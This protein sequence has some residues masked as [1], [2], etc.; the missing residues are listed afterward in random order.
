[1]LRLLPAALLATLLALPAAA[2]VLRGGTSSDTP[3]RPVTRAAAITDARVIVAPGR[4]LERA[5]VVVRDGRIV[6]VGR[7]ARVPFDADVIAGDSLW[8]YAGFVDAYA[9]AGVQKPEDMGSYNGDRGDPPRERAGI[10]PDVD[11]R[12]RYKPSDATVKALREAGFGA[13]HVVPGAGMLPGMGGVVLLRDAGRGERTESL[14]L[15]G[16]ETALAQIDGASG[17]YP[18][19]PMGVLAVFRETMENA[20]R[21]RAQRQTFSQDA[22]RAL[23][24]TYDP[25]YD[26][27][28]PVVGGERTLVFHAETWLS[29]YRALRASQEAGVERLVLAGVPDVRP[30]LPRLAASGVPFVAPLALPDTVKTDSLARSIALPPRTQAEPGGV[31]FVTDRRTVAVADLERETAILTAQ[32]VASVQS[33]EASPARLDSAGVTWAFGSFGAKGKDVLPNLRRMVGA[34]LAPD[35]ALAALT[36]TPAE[37]LGVGGA[38]G[39]VEPGRLANLVI[40]TGDLFADSSAIRYVYVEGVRHEIEAKPAKKAGDPDAVVTA[41]GT[42]DFVASV[43]GGDQTGTFTVAG[44]EGAYTGTI[45]SDGD[46]ETDDLVSVTV[47]GDV[48]TFVVN[49]DG[50]PQITVS[51]TISD[52]EF[53]GTADV[54]SFGS[55]PLTATRRPE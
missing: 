35:R 51:G 41:V 46:G 27:L 48:L 16:T 53:D 37:M 18:A 52:A 6:A 21:D 12:A 13:A 50:G 2:Q 20:R 9:S 34:G 14:F 28:A 24:P 54:G 36:T 40:A 33:A 11:V 31:S 7:D 49:Q 39:T 8:V 25:V 23:R 1:M 43:P 15:A 30:V 32:R 38:L 47:E 29:A 44:E 19:T 3:A 10:T 4:A 42:W 5:T 45:T 26:A 55:F 22:T 17:V